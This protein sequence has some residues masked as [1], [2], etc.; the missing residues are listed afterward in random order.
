MFLLSKII[1]IFPTTEEA[2]YQFSDLGEK[3]HASKLYSILFVQVNVVIGIDPVRGPN[4]IF[5]IL[6]KTSSE[7]AVILDAFI[8]LSIFII[9]LMIA[10][11]P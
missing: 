2:V 8:V 1:F 5:D 3:E 6:W 4:G 7:I 11:N 9:G 10:R